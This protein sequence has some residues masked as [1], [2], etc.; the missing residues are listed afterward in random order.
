MEKVKKYQTKRKKTKNKKTK[1]KK[2]VGGSKTPS[3]SKICENAKRMINPWGTLRQLEFHLLDV[4][5]CKLHYRKLYNKWIRKDRRTGL[6]YKN[7]SEKLL[8]KE[9]V[10]LNLLGEKK[11]SRTGKRWEIPKWLVPD[12]Y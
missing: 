5:V 6:E 10:L 11:D 4:I 12:L 7:T 2:Q 9:L 8:R 3:I 1:R